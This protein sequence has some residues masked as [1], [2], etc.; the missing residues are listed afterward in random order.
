[1]DSKK[2]L[3]WTE[4][5]V[6]SLEYL[7][8]EGRSLC[9]IAEY[10]GRTESACENKM[11]K[12]GLQ[13]LREGRRWTKEDEEELQKDW[14]EGELTQKQYEE[15]YKRS[16]KAVLEKARKM[17]LGPISQDINM[18]TVQMI[19]Y[20]MNV[21]DDTVYGWLNAGLKKHRAKNSK[22]QKYLIKESELLK[23]LKEYEPYYDASKVSR[24]LF[25]KE[26][27]WFKKKRA[28][29]AR[30]FAKKYQ[31]EW[32]NEDDKKLVQLYERNKS[33]SYIAESL[34]RTEGAVVTRLNIFGLERKRA[35]VY[36]EEELEYIKNNARNKTAEEIAEY[37]GRNEGGIVSKCKEMG[38]TYHTSGSVYFAKDVNYLERFSEKV[39]LEDIAEKL[40][41]SERS[42]IRKCNELGL[43][44]HY[45]KD[46]YLSTKQA[47]EY[48]GYCEKTVR[49]LC[50]KNLL[51]PDYVTDGGYRMFSKK[52]LDKFLKSQ[53]LE[54][55]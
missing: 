54:K 32:T 48:M 22:K 14:I 40:G 35:D 47:A 15:K 5:D 26:P 27:D 28:D 13:I 36:S 41:K 7:C 6:F 45:R 34:Q 8:N 30:N 44:Y 20:E 50:D 53:S 55:S 1:M 31:T 49:N 33:V 3:P 24:V 29:D 52:T 16:W 21:S 46:F 37:L 2:P 23:F 17:E 10:L 38:W 25:T 43:T 19:A 39:P 12:C 18:L 42:V 51:K 9:E 11:K 4:E